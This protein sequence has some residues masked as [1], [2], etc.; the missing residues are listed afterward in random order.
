M[1]QSDPPRSFS[2]VKNLIKRL[3]SFIY[4]AH[5]V[6][7]TLFRQSPQR[8]T[9]LIICTKKREKER[10][11]KERKAKYLP[12]PNPDSFLVVLSFLG[13]QVIPQLPGELPEPVQYIVHVT[14]LYSHCTGFPSPPLM[15]ASKQQEQKTFVKMSTVGEQGLHFVGGPD[16]HLMALPY[17]LPHQ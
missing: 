12:P 14:F 1:P 11:K 17:S 13:G 4:E 9:V 15:E 7:E 2:R 6:R 5:N 10:K 3:L 16:A 8:T